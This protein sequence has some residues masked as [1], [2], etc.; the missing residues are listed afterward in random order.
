LV[1]FRQLAAGSVVLSDS[2]FDLRYLPLD[3]FQFL[4]RFVGWFHL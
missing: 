3:L 4:L 2:G 1:Q